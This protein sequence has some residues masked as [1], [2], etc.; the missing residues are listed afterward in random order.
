LSGTV[1]IKTTEIDP[2]QGLVELPTGT[3]DPSRLIASGCADLDRALGNQFIITGRGGLPPSPNEP[4]SSN[5]LW[6]DTRI[7]QVTAQ[8]SQSVN[9]PSRSLKNAV[10]IV[11]A[12]GWVFNNKGQVTLIS[13]VASVNPH[14]SEQNSPSCASR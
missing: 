3:V 2:K 10:A 6:S 7:P 4:L 13:N 1:N 11:P 8:R 5:A 14:L 9:T 12:T